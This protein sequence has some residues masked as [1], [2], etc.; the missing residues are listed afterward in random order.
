MSGSEGKLDIARRLAFARRLVDDGLAVHS[1]LVCV[2]AARAREEEVGLGLRRHVFHGEPDAVAFSGRRGPLLGAEH[3]D[4]ASGGDRGRTAE[5][6]IVEALDFHLGSN[7]GIVGHFAG[8]IVEFGLLEDVGNSGQTGCV[9]DLDFAGE[10]IGEAGHDADGRVSVDV[11]TAAASGFS[12]PRIGAEDG[13]GMDFARVERKQGALVLQERDALECFLHSDGAALL[14]EAR[15]AGVG[16]VA[17]EETEA[18][19]GA[20]DA[21]QFF[22]DGGFSDLAAL[23]GGQQVLGIHEAA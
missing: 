10:R 7:P 22:V 18:D 5:V 13:D 2:R 4:V 20:E 1:E 15:N 17:I 11:G 16:L 14:A 21:A 8:G 19:G 9:E 12:R 6:G 3:R 23:D